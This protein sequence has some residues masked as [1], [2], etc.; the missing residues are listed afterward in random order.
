M[1]RAPRPRMRRTAPPA[2]APRAR[3]VH[4][5][6][7]CAGA[8]DRAATLRRSL[9]GAASPTFAAPGAPAATTAASLVLGV[10]GGIHLTRVVRVHRRR[11]ARV[12][13]VRLSR[14]RG[15]SRLG[16][17]QEG[18]HRQ[19]ETPPLVAI[20]ELDHHAIALLD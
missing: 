13:A 12:S 11:G 19:A 6:V 16:L 5:E 14:Y 3:S 2:F 4:S 15:S 18:L 8:R 1:Q 9:A 17:G 20:D 10:L 7:R